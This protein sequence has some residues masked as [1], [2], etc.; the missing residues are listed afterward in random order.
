M[1][2]DELR[3]ARETLG[4]TPAEAA[5]LLDTD[6]TTVHRLERDPALPTARKAPARVIRL[7]RAYL[8]GHRPDDWPER[9][10]GRADRRNEIGEVRTDG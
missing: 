1:N 7:Y 6:P 4:L 5:T 10:V 2:H 9:L 8:D 3:Q